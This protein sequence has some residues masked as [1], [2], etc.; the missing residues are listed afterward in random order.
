MIDRRP[1]IGRRRSSRWWVAAAVLSLAAWMVIGGIG[2]PTFGKLS[3]VSSND[4]ASFL[5][6]S[7]ESTEARAWQSKFASSGSVPAVVLFESPE[8]LSPAQLA[9]LA[10]LGTELS[11]V[12]GVS[13]S[14]AMVGP[15]PSADGKAVQFIVPV[16][17]GNGVKES[18]QAL[19]ANATGYAAGA[20]LP[21]GTTSYVTGPAGFLADLVNAFGGIDGILLFA[22]L[23]A[24]L[25]IL[26]AVYRSVVLPFVVLLTAV[27]ALCG[28]ILVVFAL[29]K[30]GAIQ[31]TGQSQGILSILVVGSATDYALL[32][33]AR[34]REAL[35]DASNKWSAVGRAYKGSFGAIVASGTTVALALL[36]LLFSE[37]NSN[38]GL[39]PI[40]AIGIVF[41]M[42]A[43]LTLLPAALGL[44][45]RSAFW[46]RTPRKARAVSA[47][48]SAA[49]AVTAQTAQVDSD[50]PRV[51]RR[52]AGIIAKRPRAIWLGAAAVLVVCASGLLQLQ[53]SGVPQ[54]ALIL[55]K[56]E[57]V[58]GQTA[59]GRHYPAGAGSPV[60]VVAEEKSAAVV[61]AEVK[62]QEGIADAFVVAVPP[63][64]GAR[65]LAEAT[66]GGAPLVRDGRVL[67]NA[68]L[69]SE[70]D[71]ATAEQTI[72]TLRQ[73]LHDKAPGTLVGGT[74]ATAADTNASAQS[75]L[76]R[77]IPIV[78]AVILLVLMALLRSILAPLLLIGTVVLSYAAALGVS[79]WVFNHVFGFPGADASVPLFGFV[80]LVALG[81]DYNIFLMTRVREESMLNGT[82]AGILKGLGATGGVITS[83]GVVLAATF[84]ALGVIPILF[85]AQI[86]FIVAFGVLLDTTIV[87]SLLVPALSYDV[88]SRIWWPG[89][90]ARHPASKKDQRAATAS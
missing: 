21:A 33:V 16:E 8:K 12:V 70:A 90:L 1:G 41:S 87:R 5:P 50:I 75:D 69:S 3:E 49:V 77:I 4:Q 20:G 7:A 51:W 31:L 81:V 79:A 58:D 80:F 53:A 73:K 85:L 39:G 76:W 22:A 28:S 13:N 62:A 18:I 52:L 83:A 55:S 68:T 10:H 2:G 34:Y 43:S 9:G 37:L 35:G 65:P 86:S 6:A 23:G 17:E 45:G 24:V 78:L 25:V 61:L 72:A 30:A 29:A 42:L 66:T 19:R 84:A 26:L 60:V 67:I 11:A 88:G 54:S 64:S 15:I 38:R 57:A 63:D 48:P 47:A 74:T 14:T 36:C 40:G 71:S 32:F 27:F 82:R 56:S 46:P 89:R 44:L 59:V